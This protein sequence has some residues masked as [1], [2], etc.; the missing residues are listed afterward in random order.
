MLVTYPLDHFR[1][2]YSPLNFRFSQ[3]TKKIKYVYLLDNFFENHS[4]NEPKKIPSSKKFYLFRK[5]VKK[6][7]N[8]DQ[9]RIYPLP[10]MTKKSSIS[11]NKFIFS[12]VVGPLPRCEDSHRLKEGQS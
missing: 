2:I 7:K 10:D 11:L 5:I 9:K 1:R 4:L 6:T 8:G 3:K 12:G